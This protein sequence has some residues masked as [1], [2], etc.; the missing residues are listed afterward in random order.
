MLCEPR[1]M[2]LW[3]QP[4][5]FV[6]S[7]RFCMRKDREIVGRCV[8][9]GEERRRRRRRDSP[10]A[11]SCQGLGGDIVANSRLIGLGMVLACF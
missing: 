1:C 5:I 6:V 11:V 9:P 3:K 10:L 4:P 8:E 7:F 2:S